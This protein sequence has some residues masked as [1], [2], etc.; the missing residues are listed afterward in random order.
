MNPFSWFFQL[1]ASISRSITVP[2]YNLTSLMR[3]MSPGRFIAQVRSQI[4][5]PIRSLQSTLASFHPSRIRMPG[6][7]TNLFGGKFKFPGWKKFRVSFPDWKLPGFQ[8]KYI[9]PAARA[10]FS[11]IHLINQTTKHRTVLHIGNKIGRSYTEA[12]LSDPNH[13]TVRLRFTFVSPKLNN[14]CPILLQHR[15][16][17]S[18]I[19]VDG[20]KMGDFAPVKHGMPIKIGDVDYVFEMY[21]WDNLPA[22]LRVHAGWKT[23]KGPVREHNEDAIGIYQHEKA[24][25]FVIADGVGGGEAGE[26]VSEFA[27]KYILAAFDENIRFDLSWHEVLKLAFEKVNDEVRRFGKVSDFVTGSTLLAVVVQGWDAYIAYVGDSRVYH[28]S[29]GSKKKMRQ[30]TTD[31]L[32]ESHPQP[33][34]RGQTSEQVRMILSKAIGKEDK[35]EPDVLLLRLQPKDRLMLCTDGLLKRVDED[36]IQ[37]Y[38]VDLPPERFAERLTQLAHERYNDDNTSIIMIETLPEGHLEDDWL[39]EPGERVY[40]GYDR[41]WRFKLEAPNEMHTQYPLLAYATNP[42]TYLIAGILIV[43]LALFSLN[44]IASTADD[45]LAVTA[46]STFVDLD[47][48]PPTQAPS[49]TPSHTPPATATPP[50]PTSTLRP[51]PSSTLARSSVYQFP[52]EIPHTV[53]LAE[54]FSNLRYWVGTWTTSH[55]LEH[56]A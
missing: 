30:V 40:V 55:R 1:I 37:Q 18:R 11:Q 41:R 45:G 31:H 14:G 6:W 20:K 34:S 16:G 3:R 19:R 33:T 42:L 32:M 38:A 27:V 7:V 2:F 26:I 39:A 49:A 51:A 5:F 22:L 54:A 15:F 10:E 52:P 46:T 28:W 25:L 47:A 24:Y 4:M 8:R 13:A 9:L 29:G 17:R 35:I 12:E 50:G 21:A 36:E 43:V 56:S 48:I 44:N 23:D 53:E